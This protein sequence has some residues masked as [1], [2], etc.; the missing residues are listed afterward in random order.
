D[1]GLLVPAF[2]ELL[3]GGAEDP[4]AG[5]H[6]LRARGPAATPYGAVARLGRPSAAGSG[7]T[8]HRRGTRSAAEAGDAAARWRRVNSSASARSASRSAPDIARRVLTST[9]TWPSKPV[10]A[11]RSSTS[12]QG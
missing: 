1:G 6:G 8:V 10:S 7:E 4:V 9:T 2:G 5:A 11:R 12:A 3:A